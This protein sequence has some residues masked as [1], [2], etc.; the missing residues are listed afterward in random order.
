MGGKQFEYRFW[1]L[2]NFSVRR[3]M[4]P[5][6]LVGGGFATLSS[7]ATLLDPSSSI[8]ID[9]LPSSE[10]STKAL[11]VV[12]SLFVAVAGWM[13]LRAPKYYPPNVQE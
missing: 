3:V 10:I 4:G 13:F 12:I 11:G 6:W 1:V 8:N 7:V 5:A 2:L 9:G